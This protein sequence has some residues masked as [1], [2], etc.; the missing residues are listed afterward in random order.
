MN[1]KFLLIPI[2]LAITQCGNREKAILNNRDFDH[3]NWL[4]VI[5]NAQMNT[6]FV[7]DDEKI[8]KENSFGLTLGPLAN[9]D[10]TTC[11]GF[12]DLYKDGV[13]IERQSFLSQSDLIESSTIKKNYRIAKAYYLYP[14]NKSEYKYLWDSLQ[15]L[16]NIYPTRYHAQPDDKD[17]ICVFSYK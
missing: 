4:I 9:C 3:N 1:S 7:V 6:M 5:E 13:L 8:L 15:K 14:N 2:I 17:Y 12:L 16:P 10:G 11:D